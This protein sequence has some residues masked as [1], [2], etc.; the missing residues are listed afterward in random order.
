MREKAQGTRIN[1]PQAPDS[2]TPLLPTYHPPNSLIQEMLWQDPW[3]VL[4]ACLLLNRTSGVQVRTVIFDLFAQ[5]PTPS[6]LSQADDRLEKL[7][8]PLGIYKRR[9]VTLRQF[10][11]DYLTLPWED[12][13]ELRGV[14][15]YGHDAWLVFCKGEWKEVVQDAALD[16]ELRKYIEYL[17]ETQGEGYGYVRERLPE[18]VQ[19]AFEEA[20]L[21]ASQMERMN[22]GEDGLEV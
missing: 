13:C 4:V 16:K 12:P 22:N 8:Q 18:R 20:K 17:Q 2:Y 5:W 3:Q 19:R 11:R 21:R 1:S 10:S 15:R 6:L 14:G 7:I 9:A